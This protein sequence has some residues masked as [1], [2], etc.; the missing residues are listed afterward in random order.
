MPCPGSVWS[1][2]ACPFPV[3]CPFQAMAHASSCDRSLIVFESLCMAHFLRDFVELSRSLKNRLMFFGI[4]SL[5]TNIFC[6]SS[7]ALDWCSYS[8]SVVPT[9]QPRTSGQRV[10]AMQRPRVQALSVVCCPTNSSG[11]RQHWPTSGMTRSLVQLVAESPSFVAIE[12]L[13]LPVLQPCVC[14]SSVRCWGCHTSQDLS[15]PTWIQLRTR[16]YRD[17]WNSDNCFTWAKVDGHKTESQVVE[18]KQNWTPQCIRKG[19]DVRKSQESCTV[20]VSPPTHRDTYTDTPLALSMDFQRC[21]ISLI[22][23]LCGRWISSPTAAVGWELVE[24]CDWWT[25][26]RSCRSVDRFD[27]ESVRFFVE[28]I[29]GDTL[30]EELLEKSSQD[31]QRW[32]NFV[33]ERYQSTRRTLTTITWCR[34]FEISW[35]GSPRIAW[36]KLGI[37]SRKKYD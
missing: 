2:F 17:G 31:G 10:P 37:R 36:A 8:W 4:I 25:L 23:V 16:W 18:S 28:T 7:I 3:F 35:S 11:S 14:N 33:N 29:D 21:A 22:C 34:C 24:N 32:K 12:P 13:V 26:I 5:T 6:A 15:E 30:V 1:F 19:W 27:V 9:S 20:P